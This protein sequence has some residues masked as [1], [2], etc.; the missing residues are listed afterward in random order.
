MF[1]R[2][3]G[4]LLAF[5]LSIGLLG[6]V[7][8]FDNTRKD[9]LAVYW[10]QNGAGSQQRLSFYCADD[11]IN[12]IPLAFLYIF[13]GTGGQPVVDLGSQCSDW[14]APVFPGT[15]LVQ[16][17]STLAADIK[18]CQ[19]KGKLITL[20]LGGGTGQVGFSS[21]S[22]AQ[23][24]AD[25]IWNE[26]L[27]GSSST[28]PFG[29]AVLDGVD[30]DIES[31]TPAHYAAFVNRI[32]SH[33]SGASKKFYITAAPQCPF[34]DANIGDAL[35]QASFDAVYVQFY[36][37][38]C[39]LNHPS[40]YNLAT[41]DNWAKT[42]SANK[43]VKVYIGAPGASD[44]AGQGYVN[45]G[46]LATFAQN[47]QK[48]FSSFGGVMLWDAD[49]AFSNNRFD[50]AIKTAMTASAKALA[51]QAHSE[52]GEVTST[53]IATHS[54]ASVNKPSSV[55]APASSHSTAPKQKDPT[56]EPE[57][58]KA[59]HEILHK[60]PREPRVFSRFFRL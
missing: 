53:A 27:G 59:P 19:A 8:A 60:E 58:V 10:G 46:T 50:K 4:T 18:T 30:L 20:S 3:I 7:L 17:P 14:N 21:D 42:Q 37:N 26:F 33:S 44:A 24:F 31:G 5:T 15:D 45:A 28:R 16:C 25:Q 57:P 56:P 32:R 51:P 34:P 49:S 1:S 9:N 29:D 22:Q 41:W 47:A 23:T 48:Q 2:G 36:N 35:N 6:G 54:S 40:D 12:V 55:A 43:N 39:G 52:G 11:T 13:R 38:F